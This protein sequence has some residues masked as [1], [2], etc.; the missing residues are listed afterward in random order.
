MG[1]R[2]GLG[3]R[4]RGERSAI[5]RGRIRARLGRAR[6]HRVW[7]AQRAGGRDRGEHAGRPPGRQSRQAFVDLAQHAGI[8]PLPVG[9]RS[10]WGIRGH[11]R[12]ASKV[13]SA[14]S[15]SCTSATGTGRSVGAEADDWRVAGGH[16]CLEI[17]GHGRLCDQGAA[18][19]D[20]VRRRASS[21]VRYDS[22]PVCVRRIT[23]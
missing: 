15:H 16:P 12:K 1:Q 5:A 21:L 6:G 18:R 10:G 20:S 11:R 7:P 9:N 22:G 13:V 3:M 2:Q 23:N 8:R 4:K 17:R 19:P 14:W